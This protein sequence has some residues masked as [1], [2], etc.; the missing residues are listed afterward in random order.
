MWKGH[1]SIFVEC[2]N[3]FENIFMA[4]VSKCGSWYTKRG[5][6]R[7]NDD[8]DGDDDYDDVDGEGDV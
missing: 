4:D 6:W 7:N 1:I 5:I 8:D 3:I 2:Y